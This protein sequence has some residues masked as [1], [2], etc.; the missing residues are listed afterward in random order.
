MNGMR[1]SLIM[2]YLHHDR[3]VA[4]GEHLDAFRMAALPWSKPADQERELS[5]LRRIEVGEAPQTPAEL[6]AERKA[7]FDREWARLRGRLGSSG[8]PSRVGLMPG[9][10]IVMPEA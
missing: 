8:L 6:A 1:L 5:R 3:A 9:E 7:M 2:G 10:R 4:A